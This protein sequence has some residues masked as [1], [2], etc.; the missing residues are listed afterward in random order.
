MSK[1]RKFAVRYSS[2]YRRAIGAPTSSPI[3][4][5]SR[6]SIVV[7]FAT[8]MRRR[9]T[10]GS[11]PGDAARANR[12]HELVARPAALD[13]VA[14]E[15]RLAHVAHDEVV[16]AWIR[17]HLRRRR[18]RLLVIVLAVDERGEPV[19][20]VALDALPHVQHRAARRVDETQPSAR[21]VSKSR[22]VTPNAGRITTSSGD[23]PREVEHRLAVG[24]V[25][26]LEDL[27]PHLAAAA[28]DVRVVDDLAD[29]EDAPVGELPARLVGVLDRALD[30]VAEAEFAGEPDRDA[31]DRQRVVALAQQVDQRAVV[32]GGQRPLDLG[33]EPEALPKVGRGC[34]EPC[35]APSCVRI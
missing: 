12:R 22:I 35:S 20:R 32:V 33:L 14:D 1:V 2:P 27:D 31:A 9:C 23:T 30:A 25:T 18:A 6:A 16:P 21:S 10:S 28:V 5:D 34:V 19:A 15:L 26:G 13:V 29:E 7:W 8:P 3:A 17:S 24:V 4:S 11:N